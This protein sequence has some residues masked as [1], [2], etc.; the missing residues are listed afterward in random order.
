MASMS[1]NGVEITPLYILMEIAERLEDGLKKLP[2]GH[3]DREEWIGLVNDAYGR[4][5]NL[6]KAE[7]CLNG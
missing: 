7:K 3:P 1:I 6:R 2:A 5:L 4:I